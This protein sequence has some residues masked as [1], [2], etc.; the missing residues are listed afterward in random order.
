LVEKLLQ[1]KSY[2]PNDDFQW[3]L[4]NNIDGIVH[5]ANL[6]NLKEYIRESDKDFYLYYSPSDDKIV[7]F[8]FNLLEND[9]HYRLS[10][11]LYDCHTREEKNILKSSF[12]DS[13]LG[14]GHSSETLINILIKMMS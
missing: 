3:T 5:W 2:I 11:T 1:D 12:F 10:V 9:N 8:H 14:R 13:I 4:P 7:V 6:Y